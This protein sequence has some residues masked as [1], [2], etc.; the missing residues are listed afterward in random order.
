M[1]IR[2]SPFV[3]SESAEA[4]SLRPEEADFLAVDAAASGAHGELDPASVNSRLDELMSCDTFALRGDANRLVGTLALYSRP[5]DVLWLDA[6]AVRR[7]FRSHGLGST[8]LSWIESRAQEEGRL[9]VQG[10]AL[11]NPMSLGFYARNRYEQDG[12][13]CDRFVLVRKSLRG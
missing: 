6:I 5:D 3:F 11:A 10:N 2:I 1:M 9:S 13:I 7:G 12:P 8:A 4:G